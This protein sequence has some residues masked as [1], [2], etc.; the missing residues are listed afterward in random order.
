MRQRRNR[1]SK[2]GKRCGNT[3]GELSGDKTATVAFTQVTGDRDAILA[4]RAR[5]SDLIV[6]RAPQ[7]EDDAGVASDV[8][9]VPRRAVDR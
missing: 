8:E 3:S 9:V 6:F 4:A 5:C 2:V 7:S 1:F